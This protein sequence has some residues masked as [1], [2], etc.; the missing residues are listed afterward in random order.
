MTYWVSHTFVNL[1]GR[2]I[3]VNGSSSGC[4]R[5]SVAMDDRNLRRQLVMHGRDASAAT[6]WVLVLVENF[7]QCSLAGHRLTTGLGLGDAQ[8]LPRADS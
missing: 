5:G 3:M 2:I 6:G 7:V 4:H 8:G 1:G